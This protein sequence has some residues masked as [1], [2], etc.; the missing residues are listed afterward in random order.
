MPELLAAVW[1]LVGLHG[2]WR[3][4]SPWFGPVL[5]LYVFGFAQHGTRLFLGRVLEL[6]PAKSLGFRGGWPL[7]PLGAASLGA[8][9]ILASRDA[10]WREEPWLFCIA[11]LAMGGSYLG[12]LWI[13]RRRPIGAGALAWILV[14]GMGLNIVA[15]SLWHSD[16]VNR[17]IVEGRQVLA[18]QNPY[19]IPPAEPEARSLV[20]EEVARSVNHPEMTAIYPPF[21]LVTHAAIASISP[22]PA[23]FTH[24]ALIA[25]LAGLFLVLALLARARIHPAH[26]LA[27][28]WNP[29]LPLFAVG[30][31]HN[32]IFMAA[33]LVVSLLLLAHGRLGSSVVAAACATL[34]KPFAVVVLPVVLNADRWRRWWVVPVLAIAAYAPFA[35]ATWGVFQSLFAFG[36]EMHF[37][38]ALDPAVRLVV[39]AT[40]PAGPV[41]PVVRGILIALLAAG[42]GWL[43]I[44]RGGAAAPTWTVR[45]L[46]VVLLCSPTFHPW[47]FIA[48][49]LLLPF[50]RTWALPVWT[51]SASIYWLH[52]VAIRAN[53]IWAETSWVTTIAHWPAILLMSW[54]AFGPIRE[55]REAGRMLLPFRPEPA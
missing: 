15:V 52:G 24:A 2:I 11:G 7:L 31:A 6:L 44:R 1:G 13:V 28:A 5:L 48:V 8:M 41:E 50:A 32:D 55:P 18:G 51:A 49:V 35:G 26:V 4:Q 40:L 54:E 33:L 21:A 12:G 3:G 23:G 20:S 25:T 22:S 14:V 27:A 19:V 38:G 9:A 53:G 17:Y 16:D 29:V 47:Y 36:G 37:H 30:E 45:A 42:L 34:F 10:S 46:A 43:W 39:R